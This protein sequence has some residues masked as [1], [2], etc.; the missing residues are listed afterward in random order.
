M[1]PRLSG[2]V[3]PEYDYTG[4]P[5]GHSVKPSSERDYFSKRKIS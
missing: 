1:P 4:F 2:E 5:F 3:P